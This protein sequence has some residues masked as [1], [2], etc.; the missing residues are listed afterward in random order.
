MTD[1]AV[2]A[3]VRV[4]LV[5]FIGTCRAPPH[6]DG[7]KSDDRGSNGEGEEDVVGCL[8]VAREDEQLARRNAGADDERSHTSPSQAPGIVPLASRPH[9][10]P[11]RAPQHQSPGE[12]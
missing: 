3:L 10:A 1:D 9:Q 7:R 4:Q 8:S 2:A 6:P 11:A 5:N 12:H